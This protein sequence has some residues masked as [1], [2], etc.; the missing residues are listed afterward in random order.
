[1]TTILAIAGL[2]VGGLVSGDKALAAILIVQGAYILQFRRP[3]P[4]GTGAVLPLAA[5]LRH[6]L[7]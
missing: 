2:A 5:L 4:S 3:P 6:Y 1:M 7:H